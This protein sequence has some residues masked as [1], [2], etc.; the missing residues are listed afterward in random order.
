MGLTIND[1]GRLFD[2]EPFFNKINLGESPDEYIEL[3]Q[4][5]TRYDLKSKFIDTDNVDVMVYADELTDNDFNLLFVL[6]ATLPK[7]DVGEYKIGNFKI[8]CP[9]QTA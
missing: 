6:R 5:N 9:N 7:Y 8:K 3:E 2:I 1:K 4:K